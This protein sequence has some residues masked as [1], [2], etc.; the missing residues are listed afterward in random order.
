LLE[1]PGSSGDVDHK[2]D[3]EGALLSEK[4]VAVKQHLRGIHFTSSQRDPPSVLHRC[5][6][7]RSWKRGSI[8]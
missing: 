8:A 3:L 6:N 1:K 5:N 7:Y 4:G 2:A